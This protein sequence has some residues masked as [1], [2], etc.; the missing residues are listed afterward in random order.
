M[1]P[2]QRGKETALRNKIV[3]LF[4]ELDVS[5]FDA[6]L[7]FYDPLSKAK[8]TIPMVKFKRGVNTL[9]L[10][11]NVQEHRTLRRIADPEGLGQVNLHSFC[12][13]FETE[14]LRKR[15]LSGILDK[16]ATAFYI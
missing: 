2:V 9:N 16:V 12:S 6:F 8:S 15:R 11:L 13:L 3:D 5:F 7:S 4:I 10:P 1:D 14:A